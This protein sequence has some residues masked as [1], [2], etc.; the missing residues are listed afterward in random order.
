MHGLIILFVCNEL[1]SSKLNFLE[2]IDEFLFFDF[3]SFPKEPGEPDV[4]LNF[5]TFIFVSCE[6]S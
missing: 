2:E 1:E 4:A 5:P 6:I 3:L